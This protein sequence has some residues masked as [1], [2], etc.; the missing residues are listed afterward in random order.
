MEKRVLLKPCPTALP[1]RTRVAAHDAFGDAF[2][3][4]AGRESGGIFLHKQTVIRSGIDHVQSASSRMAFMEARKLN[5]GVCASS[6]STRCDRAVYDGAWLKWPTG[7]TSLT[8]APHPWACFAPRSNKKGSGNSTHPSGTVRN[9]DTG[10]RTSGKLGWA[11]LSA[12]F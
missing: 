5:A 11:H 2:Q 9:P 1:G 4:A 12:A 7:G 8:P 3:P 10:A 6:V